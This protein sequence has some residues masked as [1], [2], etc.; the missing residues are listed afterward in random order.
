MTS[1]IRSSEMSSANALTAHTTT[2]A[3]LVGP[4]DAGK[5]SLAKILLNYAVRMGVA[6]LLVDLDIGEPKAQLCCKRSPLPI[7]ASACAV[8]YQPYGV[9]SSAERVR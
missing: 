1:N 6:P 5:S 8:A 3:Q 7:F 4:T 9:P 2:V